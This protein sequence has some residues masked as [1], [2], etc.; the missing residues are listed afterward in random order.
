MNDFDL[1]EFNKHA[2]EATYGDLSTG[3]TKVKPDVR[4]AWDLN[5]IKLDNANEILQHIGGIISDKLAHGVGVLIEPYK[6]NHY[7]VGGHF[8]SHT[9]T[10]KGT[11]NFGTLLI[12]IPYEHT[13]MS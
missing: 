11:M 3:E 4:Q 9:D 7:G 1:E 8:V 5:Y 12:C 2:K 6:I 13:G 10:P